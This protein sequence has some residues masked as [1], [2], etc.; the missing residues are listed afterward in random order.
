MLLL[1]LA[2]PWDA[3]DACPLFPIYSPKAF[4]RDR[5]LLFFGM[6][7]EGKD[8]EEGFKTDRKPLLFYIPTAH[9]L[10]VLFLGALDLPRT[11]P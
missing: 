11:F 7:H 10:H 2:L 6:L 9:A 1:F 8:L 5:S 4:K 3:A